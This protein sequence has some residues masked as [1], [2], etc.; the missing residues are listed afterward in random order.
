MIEDTKEVIGDRQFND[1]K[2]KYWSTK[3]YTEQKKIVQ[4]EPH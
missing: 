3:H 2:E 4:R 1:Q